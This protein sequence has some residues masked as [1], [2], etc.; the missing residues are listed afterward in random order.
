MSYESDPLLPDEYYVKSGQKKHFAKN[1]AIW[2][3]Q[4]MYE[5]LH[6]DWS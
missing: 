3:Q 1:I 4:E 2:K 5:D 6:G